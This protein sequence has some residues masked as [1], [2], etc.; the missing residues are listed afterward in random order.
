MEKLKQ[1]NSKVNET[2]SKDSLKEEIIKQ[3]DS[4]QVEEDNTIN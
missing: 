2:P 3:V 4:I 1:V